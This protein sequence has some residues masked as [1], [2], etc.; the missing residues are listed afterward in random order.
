MNG[1]TPRGGAALGNDVTRIALAAAALGGNAQFKLNF[2]K[3]HT[4]VG[5]ASDFTIRD[6]VTYTNNHDY[7]AVVAG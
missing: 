2:V 6:A 7:K 3:A 4:R 5:V 1:R